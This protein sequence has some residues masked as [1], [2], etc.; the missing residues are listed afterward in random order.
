MQGLILFYM[1]LV[2]G[3]Y[4]DTA[5]IKFTWYD[6]TGE[7]SQHHI[8]DL[9]GNLSEATTS[10]GSSGYEVRGGNWYSPSPTK[11]NANPTFREIKKVASSK[12]IGSR[13]VLY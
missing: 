4:P 1:H 7:R 9:A 13:M 11:D 10:G 2:C 12:Y 6:I 3:R 5:D 8:Y